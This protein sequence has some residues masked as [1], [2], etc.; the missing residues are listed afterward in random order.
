M[1]RFRRLPQQ[2]F[3]SDG[4]TVGVDEGRSP[5]VLSQGGVHEFEIAAFDVL[6]NEYWNDLR[7]P[8]EL[9]EALC[10]RAELFRAWIREDTEQNRRHLDRTTRLRSG[11][12][13]AVPFA[14]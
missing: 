11:R 8:R 1:R 3:G 9:G 12:A 2:D 14:R 13:R 4:S 7:R 5:R 10:E 6:R